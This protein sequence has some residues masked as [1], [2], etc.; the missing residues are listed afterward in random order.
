MNM[1]RDSDVGSGN[2]QMPWGHYSQ[3]LSGSIKLGSN[4]MIDVGFVKSIAS[5]F[6]PKWLMVAS[7]QSVSPD[8]WSIVAFCVSIAQHL[9]H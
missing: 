6:E 7:G 3:V 1:I 2:L 8:V 4:E 9:T 5:S